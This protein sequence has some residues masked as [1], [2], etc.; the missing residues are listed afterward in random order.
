MTE[1]SGKD[2]ILS[3]F[4]RLFDKAASKLEIAFTDEEKEEVK[5]SFAE[6]FD[7]AL[8]I[9]SVAK[10]PSF[11]ESVLEDMEHTIEEISPAEI[12]GHLATAPLARQ[13]QET[14]KYIAMRAAEQRL[15]EH[16]LGQADESYGGN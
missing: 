16:Y 13:V 7:H 6:R 10:F 14:M 3:A 8:Q 1:I 5:R 15:L 4:D 12:A 9:A 2:A 11:P